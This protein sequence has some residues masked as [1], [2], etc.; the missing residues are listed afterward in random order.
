MPPRVARSS[1]QI[2][3]P[4]S[5][6]NK[7]RKRNLDA[8]AI[9]SHATKAD[10]PRL[11]SNRAGEYLDDGPKHKRRRAVEDE[12]GSEGSVEED[13]PAGKRRRT[14]DE[15]PEGGDEG[16]DSEGNEWTMGGM[17]E[18]DSDEAFGESDEERFEDFTFRGSSGKGKK[19]GGKKARV[20]HVEEDDEMDL[21][22]GEDDDSKEEEDDFGDEG[23][24][25]ATM[26]DD[27]DEEALGEKDNT[28]RDMGEEEPS[29]GEEYGS[30]FSDEED[31]DDENDPQANEERAARMRDRLDAL[32]SSG[33]P[34]ATQ[35]TQQSAALTVD[36]LLATLDPASRKQYDAALKTK[37]KS[38]RPTTLSAPLPKRQQDRLN[39]EVASQK[40]KEQLDRWRDTVIQNRR[41]EFLSFPLKD[42]NAHEPQGKEKFVTDGRPQN[43]LEQNIQRIMEESGLSTNRGKNE[44]EEAA[45]LKSEELATNKLPVEEVMRRRAELRQARELL[46]REEIKAKRLSKIKSKSYRRVHRKERARERELE[47]EALGDGGEDE[48]EA[49][50]RK[51]AMARVSTKHRDSKFAKA[52]KQTNRGVWD[53]GAREAVIDEARRREELERRIRGEDV[54]EAESDVPSAD[55]DGEDGFEGFGGDEDD[56]TVMKQL[57]TLK[58]DREPAAEK[59]LGSLKF[60]RAADERRRAQNDEDVERLRK[61]LAVQDGDEAGSDEEI[62]DQGLGRA[63]FGPKGKGGKEKKRVKR[64]ELEEGEESGSEAEADAEGEDGVD[65]VTEKP[66]DQKKGAKPPKQIA[67]SGPL[68]KGGKPDRRDPNSGFAQKDGTQGP[69]LSADTGKPERRGPATEWLAAPAN[70]SKLRRDEPVELNTARPEQQPDANARDRTKAKSAL[71]PAPAAPAKPQQTTDAGNTNGWTTV[72]TTN[73]H[74]SDSS[75][76]PTDPI[77]KSNPTYNQR[78]FAADADDTT[79]AAEK[80]A[81]AA[82]EDEKE[83]SSHLPGWGSWTGAGLS[84]SIKRSNARSKHNPLFKTKTPG[85]KPQ[86]RKDAGLEKVIISEKGA[87]KGKG[88]LAPILPHGYETKEQYERALRVPVGP[89]WTTKEVFQRGTRPRVVVRPGEVVGAMEKPMV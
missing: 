29:D 9:A 20:K 55:D 57:D 4:K 33:K 46:F 74:P 58:N 28:K 42:P 24:D 41:A 32:K 77:L 22:E 17:S 80:T 63:V 78:A 6:R 31:E 3:A 89:E 76:E 26:L 75:P 59:G 62:D 84:K 53:E 70:K 65:V 54:D 14:A 16:S 39:R 34:S 72:T 48:K 1:V 10:Q 30:S 15:D 38:T 66:A 43:E 85:T 60:M 45:I 86:D 79:F 23:V 67:A 13:V 36:D 25:L 81:L 56:V 68:A 7:N 88:Y 52:L 18:L 44:D 2:A 51:R 50:D 27:D 49:N 82:S 19:G 64:P 61:E 87:R 21:S 37:K 69:W 83:E 5:A 47:R 11:N 8:Y 12:E 73:D 71:A 35:S 40:A